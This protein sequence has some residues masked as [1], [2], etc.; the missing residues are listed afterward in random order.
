MLPSCEE[1]IGRAFGRIAERP[2]LYPTVQLTVRRA[3][4][5]KFPFSIFYRILPECIEVIAVVHQSREPR[6]WQRR[7]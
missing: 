7:V 2:E 5:R 6:T 1:E 4:L 3:P